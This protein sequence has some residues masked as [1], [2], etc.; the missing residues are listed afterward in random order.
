MKSFKE[1]LVENK[2]VYSFKI[3]IA[4]KCPDDCSKQ[5]KE[6]LAQ[7][8]VASVSAGKSTPITSQPYEFPE[9]KN[10]EITI[11]DAVVNYPATSKQIH[12]KVANVL[13]K[14]LSDIRVRNPQEE[15][16]NDINHAHDEVS[17]E[18]ELGKPELEFIPGGQDMVGEKKKFS[19]L[20]DLGKTKH[21]G[22]QYKG[23]NDQLLA[24]ST[25][26][27]N[28]KDITPAV[29][30]NK[31]VNVV[32]TVG[33]KKVKLTPVAASRHNSLQQPATAKGK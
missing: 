6:A 8:D 4:G 28:S 11:F 25:P 5:I 1:Y 15:N 20:K 30:T 33:T 7:F 12:D 18:S 9:H 16:E 23:I 10:V 13:G 26:K 2:K 22:E 14:S 31:T 29:K 24:K 32:S 19:L 27:F 21:Q 3:K 17:G